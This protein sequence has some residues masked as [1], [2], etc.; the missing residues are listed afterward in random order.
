MKRKVLFRADASRK[1]G[2]GHFVRSLALADMLKDDFEC[3]FYTQSPT[4]YQRE[5]VSD[6]CQLVEL[7]EDDS[8]FPLFL[9]VLSGNE[10][11]VLDNF[12]YTLEYQQQIKEKG[13]KLVCMGG[14]DRL[15]AADVIL[16]QATTD[17]ALFHS[18]LD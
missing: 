1:I 17:P 15:Y 11:V 13:C 12:Y 9:D 3:I 16:S 10:I 5:Q 7:P 2:Y 8:K 4:S 6:V 14:P 18:F